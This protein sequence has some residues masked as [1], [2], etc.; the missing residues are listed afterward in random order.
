MDLVVLVSGSGGVVDEMP[1]V[2]NFREP[3]ELG[4]ERVLYRSPDA[5][6]TCA[7]SC[8]SEAHRL[9]SGDDAHGDDG[10]GDAIASIACRG[11]AVSRTYRPKSPTDAHHWS[12]ESQDRWDVYEG[13]AAENECLA[14]GEGFPGESPI[15]VAP[16]DAV[17]VGRAA[18]YVEL[19]PTFGS[20][21]W[22][23]EMV[24]T[25]YGLSLTVCGKNAFDC[26][27]TAT[28]G[29]WPR[30]VRGLSASG[31]NDTSLAGVAS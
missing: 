9:L 10:H 2:D 25:G 4:S 12:Y 11:A 28:F 18:A 8:V 20:P 19:G 3:M 5:S 15:D 24:N 21:R 6:G 13:S 30:L 22:G 7:S 14:E 27:A 17:V 29:Q 16:E 1:L 26:S 23:L 31:T